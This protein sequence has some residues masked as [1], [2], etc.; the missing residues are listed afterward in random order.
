[1][2][3]TGSYSLE[4]NCFCIKKGIRQRLDNAL[5]LKRSMVVVSGKND[6]ADSKTIAPY[7]FRFTDKL[8]PNVLTCS[9]ALI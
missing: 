8:K 7:A 9:T 3:N 1:M 5:Q 4:L 6:E 2:E